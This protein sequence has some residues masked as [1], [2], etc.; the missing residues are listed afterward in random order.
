[1]TKPVLLLDIDGVVNALSKQPPVDAWPEDAWLS[2]GA[3][4]VTGDVFPMRVSKEVVEFINMLH[5]ND[6]AEVRWHTTWQH[7]AKLVGKLAGFDNFDIAEA[8]EFADYRTFQQRQI[9]A[10]L[11]TW[12]K[13]PAAQRVVRDEKRSVI[14]VDDDLYHE[15]LRR[16]DA[17]EK[18][19][20][21]QRALLVRPNQLTGLVQKELWRILDFV[22]E[23][24]AGGDDV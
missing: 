10:G 8:P 12:W 16:P 15:Y 13:L 20:G 22:E 4:Y 21:G 19:G 1:M 6:L 14:W 2:F 9:R 17:D 24:G 23:V 5:R 3:E 7:R 18:L 11:P